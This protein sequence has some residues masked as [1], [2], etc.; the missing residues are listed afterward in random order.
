M[1][2]N[3]ADNTDADRDYK[4]EQQKKNATIK[5][6]QENN[7]TVKTHVMRLVKKSESGV[8]IS[9]LCFFLRSPQEEV[10]N[11]GF[12]FG[13]WF[14]FHLWNSVLKWYW[15]IHNQVI[16]RI[17]IGVFEYHCCEGFVIE[18]SGQSVGISNGKECLIMGL[19]KFLRE[20]QMLH[21]H[22]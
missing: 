21:N 12:H 20:F 14:F 16:E 1:I 4:E 18:N 11:W 10:R 17:R 5:S 3:N 22:K 15:A 7:A 2:E 6:S 19:I 8:S 9:A 13:N